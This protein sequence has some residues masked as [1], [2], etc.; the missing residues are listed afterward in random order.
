MIKT[1]W[2]LLSCIVLI[3]TSCSSDPSFTDYCKNINSDKRLSTYEHDDFKIKIPEN[4]SHNLI[5]NDSINGYSVVFFNDSINSNSKPSIT[6]TK[7]KGTSNNFQDLVND[8]TG[9]SSYDWMMERIERDHTSFLQYHSFMS[10]GLSKLPNNSITETISFL[11]KAHEDSTYFIIYCTVPFS[12][13]KLE[14]MSTLLGSAK[15]FEF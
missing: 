4:W 8:Y 11:T 9:P 7:F 13:R 6:V 12:E 10:H 15:E 2:P 5:E 3:L 14:P 1:L